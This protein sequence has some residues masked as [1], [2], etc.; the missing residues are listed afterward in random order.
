MENYWSYLEFIMCSIVKIRPQSFFLVKLR[1]RVKQSLFL[2]FSHVVCLLSELL[3]RKCELEDIECCRTAMLLRL[4]PVIKARL[5]LNPPQIISYLFESCRF[6]LLLLLKRRVRFDSRRQRQSVV[7]FTWPKGTR[8]GISHTN[9]SLYLTHVNVAD[10]DV[11]L[12]SRLKTTRK[13]GW[14]YVL[15]FG[16][17]GHT[18]DLTFSGIEGSVC[19]RSSPGTPPDDGTVKQNKVVSMHVS[20]ASTNIRNTLHNHIKPTKSQSLILPNTLIY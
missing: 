19:W 8:R 17:K 9:K 10:N 13:E 6:S 14:T 2:H 16:N 12:H 3:H 20:I 4:R 11:V 7:Q 1:F 15:V 18:L 5:D